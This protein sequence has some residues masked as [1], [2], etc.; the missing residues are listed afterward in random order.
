[1][2]LEKYSTVVAEEAPVGVPLW[3]TREPDHAEFFTL[4]EVQ[5]V[6][7][8]ERSFVRWVYQSGATREFTP[9]TGVVVLFP[10]DYEPEEG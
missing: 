2:P 1:M 8:E 9:G 6:R 3:P 7:R 5:M 4:V 10:D